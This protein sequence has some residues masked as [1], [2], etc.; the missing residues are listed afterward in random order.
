MRGRPFIITLVI[1]SGACFN[2][3]EPLANDT[4]TIVQVSLWPVNPVEIEGQPSPP[5]PAVDAR[6]VVLD[7]NGDE[8]AD[9]TTDRSGRA[10]IVV[11]PGSYTIRVTECPGAMS[12]PKEDASVVVTA[13]AFASAAL[14][15][16]TG[17][18]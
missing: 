8:V 16:D 3:T 15:C 10:R 14:T 12:G 4:G 18:R 17:I 1:L 5:R 6:V 13:G 2:A 11:A 7:E 9:A